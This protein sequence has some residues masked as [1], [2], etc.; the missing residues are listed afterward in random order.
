MRILSILCGI[1]LIAGCSVPMVSLYRTGYISRIEVS[2]V[3]NKEQ[4]REAILNGAKSA[5][6][7]TQI[8]GDNNILAT[9]HI[10]VHTLTVNISYT[11]EAFNIEYESS[12]SMKMA[13]S[14]DDYING[15]YKESGKDK[16]PQDMPPDYIHINFKTW[17]DSLRH[18]IERSLL[19]G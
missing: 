8:Q 10:R 2:D 11:D 7:E 6:W 14:H 13:C 16:C 1:L 12:T 3:F 19:S 9:Y 17:V 4:V 18:S 15:H 5:G